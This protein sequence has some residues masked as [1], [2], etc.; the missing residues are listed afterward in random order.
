MLGNREITQQYNRRPLYW[1]TNK[2]TQTAILN[3]LTKRW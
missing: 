3:H 2:L 1:L